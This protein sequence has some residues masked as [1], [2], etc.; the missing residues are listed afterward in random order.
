MDIEHYENKNM[1]IGID[2]NQVDKMDLLNEILINLFLFR[3]LRSDEYIFNVSS[4]WTIF[5]EIT[6]TFDNSLEQKIFYRKYIK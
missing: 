2:I 1:V 5:V 4:K 6:N 3:V